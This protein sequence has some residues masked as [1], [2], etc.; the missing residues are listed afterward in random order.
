MEL[1][2]FGHVLS[3]GRTRSVEALYCPDEAV[4]YSSKEWSNLRQ[5]LKS[6]VITGN[7]A[8]ATYMSSMSGAA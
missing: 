1:S 3:K 8:L 4:V 6:E 2:H 7:R 5:L